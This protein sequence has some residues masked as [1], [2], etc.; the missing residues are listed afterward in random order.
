[1][2]FSALVS[3]S[4]LW[5][6]HANLFWFQVFAIRVHIS[7]GLASFLTVTLVKMFP[8]G[9]VGHEAPRFDII[10]PFPSCLRHQLGS[11]LWIHIS[12]ISNDDQPESC[13]PILRVDRDLLS[14]IASV[15]LNDF[16]FRNLEPVCVLSTEVVEIQYF[17]R[18]L[19][20]AH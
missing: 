19:F 16:G 6:V 5:L 17:S 4:G 15:C 1:M 8:L 7:R 12:H 14:K 11:F 10:V 9:P 20:S 18:L 3:S 2:G 13:V